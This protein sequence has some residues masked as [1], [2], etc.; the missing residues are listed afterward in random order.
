MRIGK[1]KRGNSN[2]SSPVE[3][4]DHACACSKGL[5]VIDNTASECSCYVQKLE[6]K[7]PVH[8]KNFFVFAQRVCDVI[9]WFCISVCE[10][11]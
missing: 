6:R 5:A 3:L 8:A 7:R 9:T 4:L 10:G 2:H 1:A 11:T